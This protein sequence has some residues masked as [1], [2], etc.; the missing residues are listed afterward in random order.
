MYFFKKIYLF[1]KYGIFLFKKPTHCTPREYMKFSE[2]QH[3]AVTRSMYLVKMNI[4]VPVL[5][6]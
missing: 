6:F 4:E 1:M 5:E 3:R 2:K